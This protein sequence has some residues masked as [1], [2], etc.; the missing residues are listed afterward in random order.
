MTIKEIEIQ[1]ALGSLP[2]DVKEEVAKNSNTPKK[3]LTKLSI[4]KDWV[5]RYYVAEN[6][7][8]PKEVLTILSKDEYWSV[9]YRVAENLNISKE[10]LRFSH[11]YDCNEDVK[12]KTYSRLYYRGII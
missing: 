2:D 4:D 9:R 11:S 8:A 10:I 7:N 6:P 1:L 3:I 12:H 5:V